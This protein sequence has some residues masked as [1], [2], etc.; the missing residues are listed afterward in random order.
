RIPGWQGSITAL[1]AQGQLELHLN[2]PADLRISQQ[3]VQLEH[4]QL[5]LNQGTVV[6][7]QFLRNQRSIIT[8]GRLTQLPA[9]PLL[10][11]IAP[12]SSINTDLTFGGE[13]DINM[14]Q[15][16]KRRLNGSFSLRR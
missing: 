14:D 8:R 10:G 6:I 4:L 13:W 15:G 9:G 11:Y 2:T 7:E 16:T 1:D 5:A 3:E 12:A